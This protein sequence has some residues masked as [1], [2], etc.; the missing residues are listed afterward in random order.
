MFKV[1]Y[2]LHSLLSLLVVIGTIFPQ[3]SIFGQAQQKRPKVALV[4][5]GGAAKGMAHVGVLKVLEEV[6]LEPDII[7]G[8]SMGSVIGGL[9]AI[10]YRADELEQLLL[11]QDW[12][13]VL[14]DRIDLHNV[15]FEEK[16]YFE[17]QLFEIGYSQRQFIPPSGLI[18]GQQ[19]DN[20]LNRLAL[21]AYKTQD[22]RNYPI[23]FRCVAS[24]I[25]EGVPVVLDTGSLAFA[26][27]A[28][29]AIPTA[30]TPVEYDDK[31][32]IDGGLIRNF[33]VIEAKEWDADIVIGVYTGYVKADAA[34]LHNFSTI[35]MQSG[36]MMSVKDAQDQMP[37]VDLYI[38]PNLTGY[39]AQDF[40]KG[41]SIIIRGEQAAK[42]V[43]PQLISLRD[44]LN[45]LGLHQPAPKLK[46]PSAIC[47]DKIVVTGNRRY[48]DEEIIGRSGLQVGDAVSAEGLE[49]GV[50]R[51]VGTNQFEKVTFQLREEANGP[52]LDLQCMEK[53]PTV[54]KTAINYD[55]YSSAGF[56]F[57]MTSRNALLPASRLM[58][59]S[60][61]TENFRVQ[62]NYL[63]YLDDAQLYAWVTDMQFTRDKIPIFQNGTQNEEY[64]LLEA[65]VDLRLQKR[66]SNNSAVSIGAQ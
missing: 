32:L 57:N 22:F 23:S 21:P 56:R 48:T 5:S 16:N 30:F 52:V 65:F 14:S 6:G 31:I 40:N 58:I 4:L 1:H 12:D 10:G 64:T 27:R 54:F 61:I 47:F 55:N 62:V 17:N 38:E 18:Y 3:T 39:S 53:A 26:M 44:S 29:M 8:T 66:V 45:S 43:I 37:M 42:K 33:P 34:R 41:D 36:F 20:L 50:N 7:T 9:Y 11:Q 2:P 51:L 28:S 59:N 15:V 63:K 60:V 49:S 35:L 25:V 13:Q 46:P 19:V 24:D